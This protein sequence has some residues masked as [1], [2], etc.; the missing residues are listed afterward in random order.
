MSDMFSLI[1]SI[2]LGTLFLVSVLRFHGD[3]AQHSR[4]KTIE[5]LTQESAATMMEVL[6][7]DFRKLG[8]GLPVAASAI[9]ANPDTADITFMADIDGNGTA[10]T[11]RYYLDNAVDLTLTDNPNDAILYRVINGA[12]DIEAPAGVTDF[13]VQLLD[14]QG[15]VAVDFAEVRSLE[16]TLTVEG[17]LPYGYPN[18]NQYPTAVW[19]KRIVPQNLAKP[20]NTDF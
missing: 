12:N 16:V 5:L 14:M 20:S 13:S 15:N 17:I 10:E 1:A 11:I 6:E 8:S 19:T 4:E 9:V 7:D 2:S 18:N 3:A